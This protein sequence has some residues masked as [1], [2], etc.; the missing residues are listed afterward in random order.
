VRENSESNSPAVMGRITA[1]Q[2]VLSGTLSVLATGAAIFGA[3]GALAFP[4]S[5]V[6]QDVRLAS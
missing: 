5:T 6:P 2:S 3:G 1:R 4:F